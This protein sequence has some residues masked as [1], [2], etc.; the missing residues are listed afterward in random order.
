MGVATLAFTAIAAIPMIAN[1]QTATLKNGNNLG[2]VFLLNRLFNGDKILGSTNKTTLGNLFIL[3]QLFPKTSTVT[4]N[5]VTTGTVGT[6]AVVRTVAQR[7]SG[8]IVLQVQEKGQAWYVDPVTNKRISLGST[9][10][11]AFEVMASRAVG[12]SNSEF[13]SFSNKAPARLSGRFLIKPED[14]GKLY[15]VNPSDLSINFINGASGAQSLIQKFGI[16]ISNNDLAKIN[17]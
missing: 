4:T 2:D 10:S 7:M 13:N 5:A 11:K 3:D 8:R 17:L 15:Y 6:S 9:P 16:G 1:A 12:V 14:S